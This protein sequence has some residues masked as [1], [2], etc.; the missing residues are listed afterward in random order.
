MEIQQSFFDNPYHHSYSD[1]ICMY[2]CTYMHILIYMCVFVLNRSSIVLAFSNIL[3]GLNATE[4][5][6]R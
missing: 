2:M 3:V 5:R 1:I 4:E 6:V